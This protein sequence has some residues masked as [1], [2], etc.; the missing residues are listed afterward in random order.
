MRLAII[1]RLICCVVYCKPAFSEK[2]VPHDIQAFA[3]NAEACEHHGSEYDGE[4]PPERREELLREIHRYCSA[5]QRQLKTLKSRYRRD[6]RMLALV[7][8]H[9]NETV[10]SY[11]K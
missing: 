5:A 10:L 7:A 8:E 11:R 3:A 4:L 6:R 1:M 2:P 9:A